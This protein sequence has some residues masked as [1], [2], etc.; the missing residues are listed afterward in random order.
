VRNCRPLLAIVAL[1][2]LA[3]SF[4]STENGAVAGSYLVKQC[5]YERAIATSSFVWQASGVP[6]PVEHA[7]SGCS[8]FGIAARS[9][10]L[11]TTRTYSNGAAGGYVLNAPPG[12]VFT[13]FSGKF[14]TLVNCCIAGMD[15]YASA[16]EYGDGTGGY[17]EVFRGSLGLSTW[18]APMGSQGPVAVVWNSTE[19]GFRARQLG[20][21][22]ECGAQSGCPQSATGDV[23]VRGRTFEYA[24]DDLQG[25][26]IID[27]GGDLMSG[28]WI[29]GDKTLDISAVDEG[30]GLVGMGA[31]V[32]GQSILDAP[33]NCAEVGDQYVDLRPC[34][35]SRGGAWTIDTKEFNEGTVALQVSAEDVG[36]ARVVQSSTLRI[37]NTPPAP[38][39]GLL[40]DGTQGWRSDSEF[41]VRWSNPSGQ[42]SPIVRTHFELCEILN[43]VCEV[44]TLEGEGA[45]LLDVPRRG[46]FSLRL[47]LEDAAGNL[48][49]RS[50]SDDLTLRF[51]DGVPGRA[52]VSAPD[53][54][55]NAVEAEV[56]SVS[57][58]PEL[59]AG[60]L[61]SGTSG[62]S[63]T[64]DGSQPDAVI[65]AVGPAPSY[66]LGQLPE[67]QTVVNARAISGAGVAAANVG[68]AVV[69]VDRSPPSVLAV[70]V[71]DEFA[72][73]RRAVEI[74]LSSSDQADLSGVQ[75][76]P[77]SRPAIDGGYLAVR[78]DG[79]PI[80]ELR[81]DRG[82]T[83]IERDGVHALTYRA[84][85]AAGNASAQREAVF[86]IDATAPSGVFRALDRA[87][88]RKLEVEVGDATSGIED[89]RIEYRKVGDEKFK[90]LATRV[91]AGLLS[92]RMDD[93]AL[94]AGRYEMRAVVRDVAGNE[95]VVDR[96]SDGSATTLGMPLRLGAE[97]EVA[98][99]VTVKRCGKAARRRAAGKRRKRSGRPKCRPAPK[100]VKSLELRHGKRAA[101]NG[102]VM[103]SQGA[104]LPS[105]S[106]LIEGQARSGGAFVRLGTATTDSQGKFRFTIPAGPSRTVR[107]R[108]DGTNTVRPAAASLTTK[109]SA[110]A[111]LKV[112][113]RRLRNGQT[114]RFSGKL[115]GKPIPAEGKVVALQAKVGRE[116]RTFANPRANSRG[117][118]KH[119]YRFTSTTGLK[120]YAFRAVVAR[121]AAYP[122]EAGKSPIVRVTVRGTRR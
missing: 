20:Y 102:R 62:Y 31:T 60:D 81:G 85:D 15:V 75:A 25:P 42:H 19:A 22:V 77:A 108:Y 73:S 57:L 51:D 113:R 56:I 100:A 12:T 1:L 32:D 91:G 17:D 40:L 78:M 3:T 101:S 21:F 8:E 35:L 117:A 69:R 103:T 58:A 36:G 88:P 110:A 53:G 66:G 37:D 63:V 96:W 29:R 105:A 10:G 84:F 13:R 38:P 74:K 2:V 39:T 49:P 16:R 55:A 76:A 82:T 95:A 99:T 9:S 47:W 109:V 34:P 87:D 65:E 83:A 121:E 106:V 79:G 59:G 89:G 64:T 41:R 5:D 111:R 120:R 114:V 26:R 24:I 54:W 98:G 80:Q 14:G 92:A 61:A 115:L 118:F 119:R 107:Y 48:D 27:L 50:L 112:D 6:S 52:H 70:G 116:W 4:A 33:S 43:D 23:R 68:S 93:E 71:P 11:G 18:Q 28:E 90:S 104:P 72:W 97:V 122:Y 44:G 86:R 7:N 94:P 45:G 67:G 46:A 30:G